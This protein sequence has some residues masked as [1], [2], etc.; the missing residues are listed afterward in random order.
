MHWSG[1]GVRVVLYISLAGMARVVMCGS[2]GVMMSAEWWP[3]GWQYSCIVV[4]RWREGIEALDYLFST[5]R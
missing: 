3:V 2:G 1:G 5:Y 4:G